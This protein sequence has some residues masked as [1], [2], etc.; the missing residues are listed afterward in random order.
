MSSSKPIEDEIQVREVGESSRVNK[1]DIN[2]QSLPLP[3]MTV[4]QFEDA[5]ANIAK[6]I[7]DFGKP[8]ESIDISNLSTNSESISTTQ[9]D[10]ISSE[11]NKVSQA[12]VP[13]VPAPA[14]ASPA[15]APE[16][17]KAEDPETTL[18]GIES[19]IT[20]LL[21]KL[22]SIKGSSSG[23]GGGGNLTTRGYVDQV[24]GGQRNLEGGNLVDVAN[25][26]GKE[27]GISLR[28]EEDGSFTKIQDGEVVQ[29]DM[30]EREA[31]DLVQ[32]LE[33]KDTEKNDE[34]TA[35]VA[36]KEDTENPEVEATIEKDVDVA[37]E[38]ARPFSFSSEHMIYMTYNGQSPKTFAKTL[39]GSAISG[40]QQGILSLSSSNGYWYL[41]CTVSNGIIT[42]IDL[43]ADKA[44][45]SHDLE[46]YCT[47]TGTGSSKV[48]TKCELPIATEFQGQLNLISN[49]GFY[50]PMTFCANGTPAV[51]PMKLA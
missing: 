13:V 15:A 20:E 29:E 41:D 4:N 18:S 49:G 44:W 6:E 12:Q 37:T 43:K 8:T 36:Q 28:Q 46:G 30:T 16:P 24:L 27:D 26:V 35:A 7:I 31:N 39:F 50:Q 21:S 23:G 38:E 34:A 47:F 22:D 25:F 17:A 3:P 40:P 33:Q 42:D 11:I 10:D 9:I 51:Y 5:V 32:E 2:S 19:A 48:Q 1:I 14:P 45:V